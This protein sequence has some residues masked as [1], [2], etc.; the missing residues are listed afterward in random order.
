VVNNFI[1]KGQFVIRLK[2]KYIH[3]I[4]KHLKE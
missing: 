2:N 3:V 1:K 4:A